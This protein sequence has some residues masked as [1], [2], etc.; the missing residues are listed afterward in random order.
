M[1]PASPASG[2]WRVACVGLVGTSFYLAIVALRLTVA[3]FVQVRVAGPP[4][5]FAQAEAPSRQEPWPP[6]DR[7][8]GGRAVAYLPGCIGRRLGLA[9]PNAYVSQCR[10]AYK[11]KA[12]WRQSRKP[13]AIHQAEI[14]QTPS[15][16][17][18]VG[19]SERYGVRE[20]LPKLEG[21]HSQLDGCRTAGRD[22]GTS[23]MCEQSLGYDVAA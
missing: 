22:A 3:R 19:L 4:H 8:F 7:T 17:C 10:R 1:I 13:S 5:S 15:M 21:G 12:R 9:R 18:F 6:D 2:R 16:I 20:G 23:M 14:H 11:G